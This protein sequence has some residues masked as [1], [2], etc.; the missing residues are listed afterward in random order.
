[1]DSLITPYQNAFI[2]GKLITDNIILAQEFFEH[3]KKKKRNA[4][5]DLLLLN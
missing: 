3:L 1:M 5:E 2:Q 4:N